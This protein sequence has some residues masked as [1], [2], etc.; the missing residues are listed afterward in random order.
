MITWHKHHLVPKHAGGTDD[1]SNLV[2]VNIP[3]HAMLHRI[4]YEETG[5]EYDRIAWK[6]LS[7]QITNQE[8]N[9]L[10]QIQG[11]YDS[12][13][14]RVGV[15]HTEETKQKMRKPK[16]NYD[17][18][19]WIADRTKNLYDIFN[20]KTGEKVASG[21]HLKEWCRQNGI[22]D[23]LYKTVTGQHKQ[24]KGFYARPQGG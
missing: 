4:R 11:G 3:M 8:A 13:W 5:D 15:K 21:V 6:A 9:R 19:K 1:S 18:K 2:R 16:A 7:G 14:N 24:M 22:S 17:R 10:A 20:Y 12:R 23:S